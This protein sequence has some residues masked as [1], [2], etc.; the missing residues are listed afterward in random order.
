MELGELWIYTERSATHLMSFLP[1]SMQNVKTL[2]RCKKGNIINSQGH[3]QQVNGRLTV[4]V[5]EFVPGLKTNND[6]FG[7]TMAQNDVFSTFLI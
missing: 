1:H 5:N 3:L 4:N 6:V 7:F 2:S